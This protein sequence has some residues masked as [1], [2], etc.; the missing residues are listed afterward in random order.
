MVRER[1]IGEGRFGVRCM[2][3]K[4]YGFQLRASLLVLFGIAV[5]LL[6]GFGSVSHFDCWIVVVVYEEG[7]ETGLKLVSEDC[8]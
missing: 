3:R 1:M 2:S 8:L 5:A 6:L 7:G 4:T